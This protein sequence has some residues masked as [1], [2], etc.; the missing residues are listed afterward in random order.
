[1]EPTL[2]LAGASRLPVLLM[3][4]TNDDRIPRD[5]VT[6]LHASLPHATVRWR[7]DKHLR[8][9]QLDVIARLSRDVEAWLR[10]VDRTRS[11]VAGAPPASVEPRR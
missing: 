10:A 2:N 8:P 1:M 9:N 7:T 5:C 3:N 4:S 6:K 11:G